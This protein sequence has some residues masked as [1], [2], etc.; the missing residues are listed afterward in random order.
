MIL[1]GMGEWGNGEQESVLFLYPLD[2]VFR[3][4]VWL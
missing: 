1:R 2:G 4:T 3:L